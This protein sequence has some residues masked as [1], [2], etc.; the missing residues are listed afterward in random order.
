LFDQRAIDTAV[1][2][3]RLQNSSSRLHQG[4]NAVTLN[5]VCPNKLRSTRTILF[6]CIWDCY[7]RLRL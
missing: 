1:R 5:T 6:M 4:E 3:W 2:Q 7:P